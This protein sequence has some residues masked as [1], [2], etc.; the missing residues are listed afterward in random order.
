MLRLAHVEYYSGKSKKPSLIFLL[1]IDG[2]GQLV[3]LKSDKLLDSDVKKIRQH[4]DDLISMGQAD[5]RG[6]LSKNLQQYNNA[7]CKLKRGRYNIIES[8]QI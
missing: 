7:L 6:W 2:N 4:K 8:Y 5:L 1:D 3:G